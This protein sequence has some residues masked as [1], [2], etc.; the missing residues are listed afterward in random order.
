MATLTVRNLPEETHRRL[1]VR[2]AKAGR[3]MEAEARAILT[4]AAVAEEL[5]VV[6]AS[7]LRAWVSALYGAHKPRGVVDRLLAERRREAARE[8][9]RR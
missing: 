9:R 2:A 3:S 7:D 8:L 5:A 4:A 6:S 1:R